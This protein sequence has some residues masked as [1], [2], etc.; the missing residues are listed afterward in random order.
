MTKVRGQIKV[1]QI[2][3]KTKII[4]FNYFENHIKFEQEIRKSFL[5]KDQIENIFQA[6]S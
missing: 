6:L 3:N 5:V 1:G 2:E 4:A